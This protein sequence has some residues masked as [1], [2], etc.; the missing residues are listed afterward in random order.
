MNY[1]DIQGYIQRHIGHPTSSIIE[2]QVRQEIRDA[3]NAAMDEA[4]AEMEPYFWWHVKES[5]I[6]ASSATEIY[7]LNDRCL[8][9]LNFWTEDSRARQIPFIDPRE[10][11]RNGLKNEN[12][13]QSYADA[14][15]W[16]ETTSSAGSSGAAGA[17]AGISITSGTAA[18][19]KTG[20]TAF[21]S[22]DEG[23]LLR[24]N[25]EI[26]IPILT[27]T[28]ANALTLERAYVGRISGTDQD[29]T[30]GSLTQVAWQISPPGRYRVKIPPAPAAGETIYYRYARAHAPLLN[31]S[32]IPDLPAKYHMIL[33][34]GGLANVAL[35]RN[36]AQAHEM[37]FVRYQRLLDKMRREN[38]DA[39]GSRTKLTY[40]SAL[41]KIY[42]YRPV[43]A[44]FGR[45]QRW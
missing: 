31:N 21:T 42:L 37:Y 18:V 30:P 9:P 29:N 24:I 43:D 45:R 3:V 28:S 22:A 38:D 34:W 23:K 11:D 39:L 41:N 26:D 6:S 7:T 36:D 13:T 25:D 17:T 1:G 8:S 32:D 19:T 16:Y 33:V 2:D 20:G 5:S 35:F 4:M 44:D 12:A 10:M 27:Y 14:I 15:T 40:S